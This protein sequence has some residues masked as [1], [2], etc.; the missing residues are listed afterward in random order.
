M[1]FSP[2]QF[3]L[4]NY[5]GRRNLGPYALILHLVYW[6]KDLHQN[7]NYKD[8]EGAKLRNERQRN[9][10]VKEKLDIMSKLTYRQ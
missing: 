5:E 3:E 2:T 6:T 4:A 9:T 7:K 10:T 8:I 1:A